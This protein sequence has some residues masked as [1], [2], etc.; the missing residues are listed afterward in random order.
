MSE[1]GENKGRGEDVIDVG[2]LIRKVWSRRKLM[3]K[4]LVIAFVVSAALILCVPKTYTTTSK[5]APELSTGSMTDGLVGSLASSFGIDVSTM[6]TSDAISPLLYPDLM[7]DNGFI[8]SLFSIKVRSCDGEVEAT[9]YDYLDKY[10][11]RPWW[12]YVAKAVKKIIPKSKG[13]RVSGGA[14]GGRNAYILSEK[15]ESIAMQIRDNITL[16]VDKQTGVI[17]ISTVAQDPLICKTLADSV[18]VKLQHFI[19]DYRTNKARVD[20]EYYRQLEREAKEKYDKAHHNYSVFYDANS[21]MVLQT[22]RAKLEDLE[23]EM[24]LSFNAYSTINTQLQGAIAKVQERTP[25]FT[26][27][28][29]A[30]VPLKPSGPKRML[31]VIGMMALT[32]VGVSIYIL[33][34]DI[35]GALLR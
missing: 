30:S 15:D 8:T 24:Q 10:Q 9:Y 34:D 22:Y 5:L 28:K 26:T 12:A 11:S 23:N 19:T 6:Q 14:E 7:E 32:A 1:A 16:S 2:K 21:D 29:G 18:T 13:K 20:L 31:F 3:V 27:L 33:K 35:S 25:A 4:A 17:T